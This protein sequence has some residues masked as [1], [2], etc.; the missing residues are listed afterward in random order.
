MQTVPFVPSA[1]DPMF[2]ESDAED[3]L[4]ET[5]VEQN[6]GGEPQMSTNTLGMLQTLSGTSTPSSSVLAAL[7]SVMPDSMDEEVLPSSSIT[8]QDMKVF[9]SSLQR[10]ILFSVANNFAGVGA[11][12][13]GSVIRFLRTE[14]DET[15]YQLIHHS[16]EYSSRAIAQNIFKGAIEAGDASIVDFLLTDSL[17]GI[18]VN[19]QLC[20]V[21]GESCTPIEQASA[22]RHA[23]VIRSLLRHHADVNQTR[24]P[25]PGFG[26]ALNYAIGHPYGPYDRLDPEIFRMLL[27]AGGDLSES[28]LLEIIEHKDSEFIS[29]IMSKNARKNVIAWNERGVFHRAFE[30]LEEKISIDTINIMVDV[31]ADLDYSYKSD[32]GYRKPRRVIDV[33]AQRGSLE[34]V[35]VLLK[36]RA[37]LSG[38][39]LTYAVESMNEA[40]IHF[41]LERGADINSIGRLGK[42]ALDVAAQR[43]SLEMVKVLLNNRASLS[44]DTLTYAIISTNQDLIHFLIE[45]GA[46]INS[47]GRLGKTALDVA[48]QRGSLEMVKVLLNNR[49]SLSGDTLTYAIISTNQD[50]I[51]F[52]IERGADINS[53]GPWKIIALEAAIRLRNARVISLLEE[54]GAVVNLKDQGQVY[55]ALRAASKAGD[56]ASTKHILQLECQ[57]S[58][59]DLGHALMEATEKG[60][61]EVAMVLLDA[62]ADTGDSLAQAMR[63][64]SPA[65]VFALLDAG[66]NPSFGKSYHNTSSIESATKNGN[67]SLVKALLFA[68]ADVDD[69]FA[70]ERALTIAAGHKDYGLVQ[71]LLD[72]GADISFRSARDRDVTT[73][74]NA[75]AENGDL[76]M[77]RFL[78]DRGADPHDSMALAYA[79]LENREL[80]DLLIQEHK[81]RYPMGRKGF[82]SDALAQAVETREECDVRVLLEIGGN[83]DTMI[84]HGDQLVTPFGLAISNEKKGVCGFTELFLLRGYDPNGIVSEI[85]SEDGLR[86]RTTALLAAVGTHSSSTVELLIRHRANCNLRAWG[87]VKRTPL[88]RAAEIGSS[89][90]VELLLNHGA[91]VNGRA[92]TRGGGTALQFAA[93]GGYIRIACMLLDRKA[94]LDAP[95]SKV[96]GR[97]ALEG[98][99]EHGRLD[100]VQLLL[101]AGAGSSGSDLAQFARAK[102][103][104]K[105]NGHDYISDLLD[106]HTDP[107]NHFSKLDMAVDDDYE[108]LVNW[109]GNGN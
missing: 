80:F 102:A 9:K 21:D 64:C 3:L 20:S 47:I 33:A 107:Q 48:A 100:M 75:A 61:E 92:A 10:Q 86:L 74:L 41:L 38:D 44:G 67:R 13:V 62:G 14:M 27:Q 52:L 70:R 25:R 30:I 12:D 71:L 85:E 81:A 89:N 108:S 37:S 45:R 43:G 54:H 24:R 69:V 105:D 63:S 6:G 17:A 84:D 16:P 59:D 65:F 2:G 79:R 94:D 58:P 99:A 104:A 56:V 19:R 96:N 26:G 5:L 91:N 88:Q 57:I 109:N 68:G 11:S 66:A 42:T 51:H 97:T 7:K 15:L 72:A 101:N 31:G 35:K 40:L 4:L 28:R 90:L 18:D 50:L 98:A 22:L 55:A 36:N 95:G 76:R 23:G 77:A 53:I 8:Y 49:A 1:V 73:A 93:I 103:L 83:G 60:F 34:M 78:L 106:S 39:T 82:G 32:P 87:P 29:L 46:D